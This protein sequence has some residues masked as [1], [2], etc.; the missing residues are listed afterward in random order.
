MTI[1]GL[2]PLLHARSIVL[3]GGST[4]EGALGT[5]VLDN[6]LSGGFDGEIH[7]VNP[8]PVVR[9][10][11]SWCDSIASLPEAPELALIM[12]P[13]ATVPTI[14]EQLGARGTRCAV[15]L[16]GGLTE[17]NGLR[18]QLV[19]A[20]Q[21]HDVRIVGPNCLGIMAPHARINATFA[22]TPARA[23]P[24]ALISQSGA[25]ITAMLDW[26]ETRAVGF[27]SVVS[28]GNMADAD[29]GDLIDLVAADPH[30]EAILLYVEGVTDAMKF[31]AAARA[32][33]LNKPLIAIKAGKSAVAARATLSH[34][35][36]MIGSYDVYLAAFARAGF[37]LVETL[38][39]LLDAAEILCASRPT[40]GDRLAIVTNGGGAGILAVDALARSGARLAE[41][42]PETM[43][44]LDRVLPSDWSRGNPIDVLGDADPHRYRLA[45]GAALKDPGSDA[46]LIVNCPTARSAG[47]DIVLMIC[48]ELAAAGH[49]HGRKPVLACWLGDANA[50]SVRATFGAAGVPV[51]ST[52]DDAVRAFGYLVEAH[53][54]RRALTAAPAETRDVQADRHAARQVVA[55]AREEHS[56][57]LS[58]ISV[59]TL[60]K[61]YGIPVAATR[62]AASV[63][64][65]EQACFRLT[66]PYAL[67]IVSPDLPHKSDAGGVA[68]DLPDAGAAARA[69][70]EML[71]RIGQ[72]H[73][74]AR[75][76]GFAV[77]EMV[78]AQGPSEVIVGVAT[79]AVFGPIIMVGAGG[80]ATEILKDKAI[81]LLPVDHA[82][83]RA[84]IDRTR[85]SALLAG[86]RNVPAADVEALAKVVDAVSAMAVDLPDL[87]ELD[88][89]PLLVSSSGVI[90]LDA[91]ARLTSDPAPASRL[92]LRPAPMEWA[93]DL[94]TEHGLR[95]YVRPVRADDEAAV[96]RF[97]EQVTAEDLC[98]RFLSGMNSVRP[99]QIESTTRVDYLRTISFLAFDE[100]RSG[101]IA[102]AML[103]TD[104]DRT[105]AEVALTTRSDM[106]GMGLSWTLL[107]HV[108]RYA[109]SE[110][111]GAVEA[112]EAA[113][114]GAALRMEREMGFE[115][116]VD[117]DDPTVRI[118]RK[119]LIPA[120]N[121][122]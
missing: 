111:I 62:F 99:E 120:P 33:A 35:G 97:F 65:V 118:A 79:D 69:A 41:L 12:T 121:A 52:P 104:P 103:A 73:P 45:V 15:V 59:K 42:A 51:Y 76:E 47:H 85:I 116:A 117:P 107:E 49:D 48:E 4:R 40:C 64:A 53:R 1:R 109:K 19:A 38:T 54:A 37:I 13:A 68:L 78:K 86:Y 74:D 96:A 100:A 75:V 57:L 110:G 43:S 98:F 72:S 119:T 17:A 95:F 30:T 24:L 23:G 87:A 101:V 105:R 77:E 34:T 36:A 61:A 92:V 58:E 83:A 14:V 31:L 46:L 82:Q 10:G 80:T 113:E 90:A 108:L 67:K 63:E 26:A 27:S 8:R 18:Q 11:A 106:K 39:E 22:R 93:S 122:S 29:L 9:Q 70:R 112:I 91:R 71:E 89:N 66:G 81:D 115:T 7:V 3:I 55:Q 44:G 56:T 28:V 6:L 114:H 21:R 25:L 20:A 88:I 32:A 94:V 102:M 16:S 84:L 60:L 2:S 50:D 5:L